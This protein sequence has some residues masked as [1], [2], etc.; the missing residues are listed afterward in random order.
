LLEKKHSG[1]GHEP[2]L[3]LLLEVTKAINDNYS[4]EQLIKIFENILTRNLKIPRYEVYSVQSRNRLFKELSHGMDGNADTIEASFDVEKYLTQLESVHEII[5]VQDSF[6]DLFDALIPVYHKDQTLAYVIAGWDEDGTEQ[7]QDDLKFVQALANIIYVAFE[8]KKLAKQRLE[9][10]SLRKELELASHMQSMLLPTE[11][12]QTKEITV[13]AIYKSHAEVGGDYY[14]FF[15]LNEDEYAL[16]VADVSGK[17][18]SAALLMS[19][20]QANVRAL[21]SY[22]PTLEELAN[23]LNSKVMMSAKGEKFITAFLGKYNTKKRELKYINAGHN[24]PVIVRDGQLELLKDGCLGLGM[25]DE[26]PFVKMKREPI[27]LNTLLVCYTDGLTELENRDE[28]LFGL[29][30]LTEIVRD[31]RDC[32]IPDLLQNIITQLNTFRGEMPYKD[33]IAVMACKFN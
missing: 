23:I 15:R 32:D 2:R 27:P 8:N 5:Y 30:S 6:L 18:V 24:P 12:P 10:E 11:L 9:Q 22:V 13:D 21:F 19:N 28:N 17:G 7:W 20:F 31:N 33:D 26:L 25:L 3:N 4:R 14:D 1:N 29:D 16:C